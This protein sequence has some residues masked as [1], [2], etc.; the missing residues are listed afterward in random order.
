MKKTRILHFISL[1]LN[2]AILVFIGL[3]LL[4]LSQ[5]EA[6]YALLKTPST[7]MNYSFFA[8]IITVFSCLAMVVANIISIKR[9]KDSTPRAFF[10]A[11]FI[12]AVVSTLTLALGIYFYVKK[13]LGFDPMKDYGWSLL[14]F[15]VPAL[16]L[17]EF[18]G[19]ELEPENKFHKTFVPLG[20]TLFYS[21]AII[22]V[23]TII[24]T[25]VGGKMPEN[26]WQKIYLDEMNKFI[27]HDFFR[28][29]KNLLLTDQTVVG[30]A[31]VLLGFIAGS[32]AGAIVV[33]SLN[34]IVSSIVVGVS[35]HKEDEN[36]PK[37]KDKLVARFKKSFSIHENDR[38]DN[39]KV[40]HISY[41][42][43]AKKTWKVKGEGADRANKIFKNQ[44]EA[45]EFATSLVKKNGGSIRIHS[46]TGRI[47]RDW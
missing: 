45:I 28:L 26:D 6:D 37:M 1:V 40:Y 32:Y 5:K 23:I 46:M 19:T 16:S 13:D 33:W 17:I 3:G 9:G 25:I 47:R 14:Y 12:S 18:V 27:P 7:Y 8:A 36:A 24:A 41:A 42:N 38:D 2:L 31:F 44:K 35:Y 43:R 21:L 10:N 39:S 29:H 4:V 30:N 11:R 20:Y 15:V 34:R 22:I